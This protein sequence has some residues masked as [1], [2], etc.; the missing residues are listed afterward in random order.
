MNTFNFEIPDW[1][2]RNTFID[3]KKSF[4]EASID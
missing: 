1:T 3:K 2:Q 4:V